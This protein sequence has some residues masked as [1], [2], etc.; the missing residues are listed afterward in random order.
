MFNR[1]SKIMKKIVILFFLFCVP[2]WAVAQWSVNFTLGSGIA[3]E[4]EHPGNSWTSEFPSSISKPGLA[5]LAGFDADYY[6]RPH[7]GIGTGLTLAYGRSIDAYL[8]I[9]SV[10]QEYWY[11]EALRVPLSLVWTPGKKRHST[12]KFGISGNINL[13]H[14]KLQAPV[15]PSYRDNP[16]FMGAHIGYCYK[17]DRKL[18][19]GLLLN[20]DLN[21]FLNQV[22]IVYNTYPPGESYNR[23]Y[24]TAVATLSYQL[25]GKKMK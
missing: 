17:F 21:W 22:Y 7:L 13:R 6:F 15:Q 11:S 10:Y 25:W 9:A 24:F 16:F 23:Y 2:F 19:I 5:V 8:A 14:H 3:K 1:K 20:E 12:F 18:K 4:W